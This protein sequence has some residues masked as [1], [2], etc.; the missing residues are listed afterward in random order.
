MLY[1]LFFLFPKSLLSYYLGVLVGKT[2]PFQLHTVIKTWF[3]RYYQVDVDE[4]EHPPHH[5]PT[6]GAFFTRTL[7]QD[8]RSIGPAV[9]VSPVDGTL[10]QW[11]AFQSENPQLT[12]IKGKTYSLSKLTGDVWDLADYGRGG[13]MTIY[14]APHNYHRIHAP[15]GGTISKA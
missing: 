10:T 2:L 3:I 8:A 12:Q 15:L 1:R 6:L 4:S 14:L 13:Y 9:L 7:K 11:G 5:Y